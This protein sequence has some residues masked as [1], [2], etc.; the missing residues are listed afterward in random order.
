MTSFLAA[1]FPLESGRRIVRRLDAFHPRPLP[2]LDAAVVDW[3]DED[4]RPSIWQARPLEDSR[5]LSGAFWGHLFAHLVLMP[6]SR[7]DDLK[8]PAVSTWVEDNGS[9]SHLGLNPRALGA[10]RAAMVPGTTTIFVLHDTSEEA[11]V[12]DVLRASP[13]FSARIELAPIEERRLY[14]GFGEMVAA[15]SER[16]AG[17]S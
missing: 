12:A 6:L 4:A 5:A 2:V 11:V 16:V 3:P 8:A 1:T 7:V 10:L 9:L 14:A 17:Q 15:P 13:N